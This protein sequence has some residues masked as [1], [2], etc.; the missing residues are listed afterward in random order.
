[1]TATDCKKTPLYDYH[2]AQGAKMVPFAGYEMPVQY[3]MGVKS[4][5]LHT[6][7]LAGLFDISHMGPIHISG[8]SAA[9]VLETLLPADVLGLAP[10]Q[11]VY[12]VLPNE[13]GGIRDDLIVSNMGDC[14]RL[15]V[16]AACK[17]A[18][19]SYIRS[20]VGKD[21]AIE[22]RFDD[23]LIA[24][25]GPAARAVVSQVFPNAESMVFMQTAYDQFDGAQAVVSCSGYTGEDG[26]EIAVPADKAVALCERLQADERLKPVG[27]GA[28]DSLRLEAGLCL[29][30]H[31]LDEATSPA[32]A[33]LMW[34]IPKVRRADGARAG[35]FPGADALWQ[36]IAQ[37]V[38]KKRVGLRVQGK[39]PVREGAVLIDEA[40]ATVGSVCSGGFG[41]SVAAPIAMAYI[42]VAHAQLGA[43]V[44][45]EL[46]G[47]RIELC[48]EKMPFVPA[49]YFRG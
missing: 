19:L 39:A 37:G 9:A 10:G 17:E 46:R 36:K 1:M 15:V 31:D 12:T 28:R 47:R 27:L 22:T 14:Y 42:D 6:R 13:Q 16:N 23:A 29:Y 3:P 43:S 35:G 24:V 33:V 45:T 25:Q 7:E 49:R 30:G 5:H 20:R 11:Q 48:V 32:E 18:D 2:V 21:V 8:E 41:P 26:F 44:F 34:S 38:Q 4:E 40:G